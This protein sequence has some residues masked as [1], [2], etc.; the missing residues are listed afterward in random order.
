MKRLRNLW[1]T[2]F[3]FVL[4]CFVLH[5]CGTTQSAVSSRPQYRQESEATRHQRNQERLRREYGT[6]LDM[7][8]QQMAREFSKHL[9]PRSGKDFAGKAN[10]YDYEI[11]EN[12]MEGYI[13]CHATLR[14]MARD[15]WSGVSYDWCELQGT[16]YLYPKMRSIDSNKAR[17]TISRK[18]DHVGKISSSSDWA[19]VKNGLTIN[20]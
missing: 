4:L 9:S 15:F 8:A 7:A 1:A 3:A 16:L 12:T 19:R 2:S 11:V 18:N 13:A 10:I 20:L 14:W 5:S 6:S 17:F